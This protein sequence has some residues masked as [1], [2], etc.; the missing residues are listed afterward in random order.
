MYNGWKET[1][2]RNDI[3]LKRLTTAGV[4]AELRGTTFMFLKWNNK[5]DFSNWILPYFGCFMDFR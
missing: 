3:F 5:R 4:M 2:E 1:K